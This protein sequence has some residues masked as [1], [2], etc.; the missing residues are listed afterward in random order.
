[1]HRVGEVVLEGMS[2]THGL[3]LIPPEQLIKLDFLL[4][5][6]QHLQTVVVVAHILL[7]YAQHG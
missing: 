5:L 6:C 1:M 4:V 7:V 2:L 3:L